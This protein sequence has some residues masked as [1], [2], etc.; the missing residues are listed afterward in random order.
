[1]DPGG[2]AFCDLLRQEFKV[3]GVAYPEEFFA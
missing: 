1:V 3:L 2:Q